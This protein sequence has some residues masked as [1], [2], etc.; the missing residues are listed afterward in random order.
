MHIRTAD[1]D[2]QDADDVLRVHL[3][4]TFDVF[5]FGEAGNVGDDF[6]MVDLFQLRKFLADNLVNA[7]I[8]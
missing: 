3:F 6:F 7:R 8:L 4:R 5:L 1:V 2:L